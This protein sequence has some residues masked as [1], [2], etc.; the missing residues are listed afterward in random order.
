MAEQVQQKATILPGQMRESEYRRTIWAAE[1]PY[2]V[3]K[4]RIMAP[5]FWAHVAAKLKPRDRIEVYPEDGSWFAEL[6]VIDSARN[7][8][9]VHVM[10]SFELSPMP[11]SAVLA[12]AHSQQAAA[13][14]M[15]DIAYRG[16]K[17]WSVIRKTDRQ[18]MFE[19]GSSQ[20]AAVMWIRKWTADNST[21]P[22]AA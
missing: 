5:D 22:T 2:G 15:F 4:D 3:D 16:P 1:L 11:I 21:M 8:A 18:V 17:R 13:H 6:M 12:D 9:R 20:Q 10:Q 19:D 7:W 14:E